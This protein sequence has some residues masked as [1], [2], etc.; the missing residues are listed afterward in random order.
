MSYNEWP[1][2]SLDLAPFDVAALQYLYG[3]NPSARAGD[4]RYIVNGDVNQIIWDGAGRDLLDA[5]AINQTTHLSLEQGVWSWVGEEKGAFISDAGQLT[6]NINTKIED[7][8]GGSG[9]DWLHGNTLANE[10]RGGAGNDTIISAGGDD[11]L[12][13]GQGQDWAMFDIP[14][15][16]VTLKNS[17][18]GGGGPK[19]ITRPVASYEIWEISKGE[20]RVQL[21]GIERLRFSDVAVGLDV[22]GLTGDAYSLIAMVY[23]RSAIS[24]EVIGLVIHLQD[25]GTRWDEL[26]GLATASQA[27]VQRFGSFRPEDLGEIVWKNITGLS[28]DVAARDL[29]E[30]TQQSFSGNLPDWLG[31]LKSLAVVRN[32][33]GLDEVGATGIF[34]APWSD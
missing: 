30:Q 34:F 29:I 20:E 9:N 25:Q 12:F 15:D 22:D 10:I 6:I 24:P 8:Y 4:D 5:S 2:Y 7:L 32:L 13:G 21:D 26:V 31:W 27:Y 33:I 28:P 3:P 14:F 19:D 18:S 16:E 1:P 23:G 11:S 17:W